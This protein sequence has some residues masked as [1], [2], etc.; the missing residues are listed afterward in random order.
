MGIWCD[1]PNIVKVYSADF[2][3]DRL[4]EAKKE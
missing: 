1:V 4:K 2:K 3:D